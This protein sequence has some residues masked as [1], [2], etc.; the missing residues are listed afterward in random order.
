MQALTIKLL[1]TA[2]VTKAL[3]KALIKALTSGFKLAVI[4]RQ[5][6]LTT[7]SV[8]QAK[9]LHTERHLRKAIRL[10]LERYALGLRTVR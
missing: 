4:R 10:S 3:A 5:Y 8:A 9:A 1:H 2:L 7:V 6:A